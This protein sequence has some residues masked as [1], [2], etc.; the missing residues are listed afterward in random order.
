MMAL[1]V[2]ELSKMF[3]NDFWVEKEASQTGNVVLCIC[4]LQKNKKVRV[5]VL[6]NFH[7]CKKIYI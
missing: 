2:N 1:H 6:L 3:V 5:L 4:F 7:G